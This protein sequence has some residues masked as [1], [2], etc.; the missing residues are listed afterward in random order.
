MENSLRAIRGA[1]TVEEN[2]AT[3]IESATGELL[4]E[5]LLR[6]EVVHEALVCV[7][8]S[9]TPDLTAAFPAAGARALGLTDVPLFGSME[10]DV[11]GALERCIRVMVQCYL[12]RSRSEIRHVYTK[13]AVVL[14]S[15]LFD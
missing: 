2:K 9:A 14:R 12:P 11:D 1:T 5:I 10:L 15:D 8:F 7:F 4:N 6:N 13:G 3:L